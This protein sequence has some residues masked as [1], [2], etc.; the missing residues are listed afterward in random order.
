MFRLDEP[1][2]EDVLAALE[3]SAAPPGPGLLSALF[4][5]FNARVP[6]ENASKIVRD[7]EV[8]D[9]AEK[10]RMPDGF[11]RDHLELGTGGTC[12]ARVAAFDALLTS[13]GF[14]CHIA[15]GR[16]RVDFDH[17]ALLVDTPAGTVIADVGFPLPALLPAR[18][19]VVE[20]PASDLRLEESGRGWRVVYDGGVPEGPRDL[21]IFSAPIPR[22]ELAARWRATFTRGATFLTSVVLRLDRGER[23]V[24]F[25]RGELRVDDRHT[26]LTLPLSAPRA[27]ALSEAFGVDEAILA[28]ALEIAGDPPPAVAAP[29]LTAYLE[30]SS[31]ADAAF[32]AIATAG[33]YRRLLEGLGRVETDEAAPD[34][35][36]LAVRPEAPPSAGEAA[37]T[38]SETVR[39]R[40]ADRA[41]DVVRE[42]A[43]TRAAFTLRALQRNGQSW[44]VREAPVSAPADALLRNDSLRG[45]LAGTFAA[46]LLGWARLL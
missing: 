13:L 30:S 39:V 8:A 20:T 6:F 18:P 16:V 37:P 32:A 4:A 35:F 7:A 9:P 42:G 23:L 22:E 41:V 40:P 27:R 11:W 14:S 19:G 33:G 21:E 24:S 43:G 25:A 45:R 28:R 1:L 12:F 31:G 38:L 29:T 46:D 10:P 36:R 15:L 44:L 34:G 3:I 26:R 17:A 2:L 5:R